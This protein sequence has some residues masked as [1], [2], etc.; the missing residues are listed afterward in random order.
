MS[1]KKHFLVFDSETTGLGRKAFIFDVGYVIATRNDIVLQR[2]FLVREIITN[3]RIMLGAL[4]NEDWRAMMGGK[5]FQD[6]I[7]ALHDGTMALHG[8]NDITAQMREDMAAHNVECL[9]AYNLDFD[10]RAIA[11]TQHKICDGGKVLDYKPQLLCLWDFACSTVCNT[12]LY[13]EVARR[14]GPANGWITDANNVRTTA[15]KVY[16]YLSGNFDY[17]EPHTA[18]GDA[19]IE[20]ELLQRFLAMKK[21]IPYDNPNLAHP[22][23]RAQQIRGRLFDHSSN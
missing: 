17:I 4:F 9:A 11:T 8:W 13:H 22:W 19:L 1:K 7:P 12:N 3:P 23:R 20:A 14:M 5:L 6:Y 2:S 10:K 18:L 15:E 21:T 16:A